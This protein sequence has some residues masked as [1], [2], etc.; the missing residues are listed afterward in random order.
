MKSADSSPPIP[1]GEWYDPADTTT[2]AAAVP[3]TIAQ[4]LGRE[5]DFQDIN[6]LDTSTIAGAKPLRSGH[7]VTCRLMKN[8]SGVVLPPKR[9]I[10]YD[11]DNPGLASGLAAIA[12]LGAPIGVVD[13]YIPAAGVPV[14]GIFWMVVKGRSLCVTSAAVSAVSITVGMFCVQAT[15]GFI[16][17]SGTLEADGAIVSATVAIVRNVRIE[18]RTAYTGSAPAADITVWVHPE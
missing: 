14:N 17:G 16:N 10:Y 15:G 6:L 13:E 8:N 2:G 7:D 4:A 12:Q 5:W 9:I 18:A 1:R 3:A 11:R